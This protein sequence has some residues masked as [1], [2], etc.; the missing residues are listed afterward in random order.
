MGAEKILRTDKMGTEGVSTIESV[1]MY[2]SVRREAKREN[3]K[4]IFFFLKCKEI[5]K[6]SRSRIGIKL[7]IH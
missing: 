5:T 1:I 4:R 7:S 2:D 6:V 3:R